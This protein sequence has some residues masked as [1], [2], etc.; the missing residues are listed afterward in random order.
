MVLSL[1][2][3]LKKSLKPFSEIFTYFHT[4]SGTAKM[5][6]YLGLLIIQNLLLSFTGHSGQCDMTDSDHPSWRPLAISE[7]DKVIYTLSGENLKYDKNYWDLPA[8]AIPL[9]PQNLS[10]PSSWLVVVEV[11]VWLCVCLSVCLCNN[12]KHFRVDITLL[13]SLYWSKDMG[14]SNIPFW[15]IWLFHQQIGPKQLNPSFQI[16]TWSLKTCHI[17]TAGSANDSRHYRIVWS[18]HFFWR[19]TW[20]IKNGPKWLQFAF[21]GSKWVQMASNGSKWLN[22]APNGSNW[23]QMA[24]HGSTWLQ[25]PPHGS[26]C[27]QMPPNASKRL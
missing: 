5:A 21:N 20:G 23:L 4:N 18:N 26:K 11:F 15:K 10:Y 16:S 7:V 9:W 3:F 22:I 12:G 17:W 24:P 8:R 27:L 13:M 19:K 25:M 2:L 1:Q 6:L 14:L